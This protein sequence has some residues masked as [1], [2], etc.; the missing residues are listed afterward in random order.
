MTQQVTFNMNSDVG[1]FAVI[2]W[3]R[4][5]APGM[6]HGEVLIKAADASGSLFHFLRGLTSGDNHQCRIYISSNIETS[7][8]SAFSGCTILTYL[9]DSIDQA[10]AYTTIEMTWMYRTG[11]QATE[12]P[13]GGSIVRP[14]FRR[15]F[16]PSFTYGSFSARRTLLTY[17][18]E[19]KNPPLSWVREG[20]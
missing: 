10:L 16:I 3:D 7:E 9:L 11:G 6:T 13:Y 18:R 19:I 4:R 5:V 2:G 12:L 15:I 8:L 17:K 1:P 20:L 14:A